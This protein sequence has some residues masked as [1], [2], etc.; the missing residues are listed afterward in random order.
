[1]AQTIASLLDTDE[2]ED[3]IDNNYDMMEWFVTGDE[4]EDMPD[5]VIDST[6]AEVVKHSTD[7]RLRKA[8][9]DCLFDTW[10]GEQF[11]D[12]VYECIDDFVGKEIK[13]ILEGK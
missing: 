1:M 12:M 3:Y 9:Y 10:M 8:I 4:D 7:G 11:N 6:I 13:T 2:L 5:D